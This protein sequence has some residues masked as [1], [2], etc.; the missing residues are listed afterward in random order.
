MV[1]IT[2]SSHIH[3]MSFSGLLTLLISA[4]ILALL[5]AAPV[6]AQSTA[7]SY[8]D[9]PPNDPFQAQLIPR[10]SKIYIAPMKPENPAKPTAEGFESYMAAALRKKSVPLVMVADRTQAD[11]II[12]GSADKRGA[13]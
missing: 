10:N 8:P 6:S 5:S 3:A 12:E 4:G 13:G 11:F 1:S 2:R 9:K 7:P